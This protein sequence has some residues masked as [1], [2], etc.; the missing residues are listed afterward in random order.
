[1]LDRDQSNHVSLTN[2]LIAL[3]CNMFNK[4]NNQLNKVIKA[5]P[6]EYRPLDQKLTIQQDWCVFKNYASGKSLPQAARA[7]YEAIMHFG[8]LDYGGTAIIVAGKLE[9]FFLD[10]PFNSETTVIHLEK[11]NP[12]TNV[13]YATMN[14]M[15]VAWVWAACSTS[16]TS[17]TRASRACS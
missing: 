13:P 6:R 11:A 4:K 3:A 5:V 8:K 7:I 14:Q 15:F 9:V 12:A 2:E 17:R 10:E 1:M 16:T